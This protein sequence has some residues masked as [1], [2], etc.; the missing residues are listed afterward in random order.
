[1]K[2][3]DVKIVF[4]LDVSSLEEGRSLM[5]EV[6]SY[7]DL[8]KVGLQMIHSVGT[9]AAIAMPKEFGKL[10]FA[11][12]KLNDIPNT[13]REAA[14]AITK[15]GV[16]SFN[17]MA[18]GGRPMM[19]AAMQGAYEMSR[20][21]RIERPKVIA[22]TVLTSLTINHL[23]ELGILPSWVFR[24][25][26]ELNMTVE[27]VIES[28]MNANGRQNAVT[29]IV[30]QWSEAAV[31]AGVDVILSSPME[32]SLIHKEWPEKDLYSP[33]LRMPYS[34][35]DDQNRTLS[36]GEAVRHGVKYLVIGRPI[37]NPEGGRTRKQVIDEI[38]ADISQALI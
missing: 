13:V 20:K 21:M 3:E 33:G 10:P 12:V 28:R 24:V 6:G 22:V 19:E 9:P 34:P 16:H 23:G 38:R 25:M 29:D 26:R 8:P 1:M 4:P 30:M 32:S 36:P 35:P 11:D 37:R 14:K 31:R 7:I 27:E 2:P 17:V 15:H 18:C 5:E